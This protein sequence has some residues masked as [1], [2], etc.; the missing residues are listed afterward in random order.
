MYPC[1]K[2]VA[3]GAERILEFGGEPIDRSEHEERQH[4]NGDGGEPKVA[5]KGQGARTW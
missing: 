4:G 1:G 3:I 5:G 2:V